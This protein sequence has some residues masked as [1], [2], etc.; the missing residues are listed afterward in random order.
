M[1][2]TNQQII[3]EGNTN[4]T[5]KPGLASAVAASYQADAEHARCEEVA[6][7]LFAERSNV[8]SVNAPELI[9]RCFKDA[10]TF[11]DISLQIAMGDLS[12]DK[13]ETRLADASAPNLASTHPMNLISQRFVDK[14]G[15]TEEKVL[16]RIADICQWL[17]ENPMAGKIQEGQDD[18]GPEKVVLEEIEIKGKPNIR[19]MWTNPDINTARL[20]LPSV[21]KEAP[22]T[23]A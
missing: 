15:G 2:K 19:V 5:P 4:E 3:D 16:E 12:V 6:L 9:L 11:L 18:P 7:Q 23:A 13:P 22:K 14:N 8:R 1:A 17:K 20:I 10:Q 21:I